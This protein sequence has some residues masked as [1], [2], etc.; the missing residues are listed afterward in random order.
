MFE[1]LFWFGLFFVCFS[2]ARTCLSP[3]KN[4]FCVKVSVMSFLGIF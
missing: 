2:L 3:Q 4:P 1:V